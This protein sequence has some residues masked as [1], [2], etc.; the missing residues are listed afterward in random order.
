[1]WT[2]NQFLVELFD[3]QYN[4]IKLDSVETSNNFTEYWYHF[5]VD[6]VEYRVAIA[7]SHEKGFFER[8]FQWAHA[9]SNGF[10]HNHV[11]RPQNGIVRSVLTSRTY[12][13]GSS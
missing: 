6:T 12:P 3:R 1:M 5:K 13:Q 2:F 11:T 4:D 9:G 7:Y 10:H 8:R